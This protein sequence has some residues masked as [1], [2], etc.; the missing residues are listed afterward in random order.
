MVHPTPSLWTRLS[1]YAI[2]LR[3]AERHNKSKSIDVHYLF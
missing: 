2:L 3:G 1:L